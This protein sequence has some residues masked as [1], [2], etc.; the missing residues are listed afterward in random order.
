MDPVAPAVAPVNVVVANPTPPGPTLNV[1]PLYTL[2]V[3][4]APGPNVKVLDPITTM[5]EPIS[6]KVIP[7]AV[8][9]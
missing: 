8:I 5:D 7:P 4:L 9:A 6:E 1:L 3:L 2:V